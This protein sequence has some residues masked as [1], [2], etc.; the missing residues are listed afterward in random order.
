MT[1]EETNEE[2]D[3]I[4][5]FINIY[6]F[7]KKN[8]WLLFTAL[9]LG[10]ILG[11]STKFLK[12]E[13]FESTMLI[14]SKILDENIVNEYINNIHSIKEDDNL[15]LLSQKM[16]I[17][18]KELKNLIKIKSSIYYK[19]EHEAEDDVKDNVKDN[20]KNNNV[21]D[22][23]EEEVED[24]LA[25]L[26]VDV[27]ANNNTIFNKLAIGISDFINDE[28]YVHDEI[29][30]FKRDAQKLIHKIEEEI[31]KIE[32]IQARLINPQQKDGEIKIY[33]QEKSLHEELLSLTKEKYELEKA[34]EYASPFRV[35][36][37]FTVYQKPESNLTTYT[38]QGA[39]LL[40]FIAL[41]I[42]MIKKFNQWLKEKGIN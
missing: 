10:A 27:T 31:Y 21:K 33:Y 5:V 20:V 23:I 24:Q 8:F 37:D 11:Y 34:I 12:K 9:L 2:I 35:I 17:E 40:F 25:Y 26:I 29:K 6:V 16:D 28:K 18:P 41:L 30:S 13:Y 39:L 15:S 14:E 38:V 19:G 22:G 32:Q 3:L 7:L 36:K 4:E 42:L 1:K